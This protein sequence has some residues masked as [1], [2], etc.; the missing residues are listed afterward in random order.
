M[1]AG[2]P[3]DRG[4]PGRFAPAAEGPAAKKQQLAAAATP[5]PGASARPAAAA[6]AP[7]PAAAPA[8]KP[9]AGAFGE[10]YFLLAELRLN[11]YG[12]TDLA[13]K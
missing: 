4:R 1:T 9:S 2:G 3:W 7:K 6:A 12:D 5:A 8:T 13:V 10:C 11:I